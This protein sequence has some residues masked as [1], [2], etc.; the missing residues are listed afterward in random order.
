MRITSAG[1]ISFGSTGTAYGTSGQVLTSNG[2][3]APTWQAAGGGTVTWP[4]V[5]AGTRTT[6]DLIFKPPTS[7][8]AGFQFLTAAG[9]GAGYFLIRGTSD[10]GQIYKAE[11]ITLVSDSSWV[12]IAS[13]TTTDA[14]V[15]LMSGATSAERLVIQDNG[16]SHFVG[17][18][19]IGTSSTSFSSDYDNLIVGTGVGNNGIGIYSGTTGNSTLAFIPDTGGI[20][21]FQIRVEHDYPFGTMEVYFQHSSDY[22]LR[23]F[24]RSGGQDPKIIVGNKSNF[25]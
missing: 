5:G 4:N 14:G 22:Y 11:G 20:S 2:N 13:R 19:G 1:G 6:L 24:E 16:H 8:Y 15:R 17:N 25:F 3:A 7:S 23:M 21:D 9:A 12:T 10:A 18:L